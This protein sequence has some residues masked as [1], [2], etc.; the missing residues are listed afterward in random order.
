MTKLSAFVSTERSQPTERKNAL[1]QT[2]VIY[3]GL[4]SLTGIL[5]KLRATFQTKFSLFLTL[6]NAQVFKCRTGQ[7]RVF[8]KQN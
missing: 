7:E 5:G 8:V 4:L 3:L 2:D 6:A 1:S